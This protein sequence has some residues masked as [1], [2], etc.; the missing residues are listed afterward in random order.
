MLVVIT[1]GVTS[2]LQFRAAE[3]CYSRT[4]LFHAILLS[5]LTPLACWNPVNFT[6]LR[7]RHC[8][9]LGLLRHVFLGLPRQCWLRV[10]QFTPLNLDNGKFLRLPDYFLPLPFVNVHRRRF[11]RPPDYFL[12]LPFVYF[13]GRR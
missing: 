11:L 2:H 1:H 9:A 3:A 6:A 5:P 10:C 8:L 13:H 7:R 4:R 12:P